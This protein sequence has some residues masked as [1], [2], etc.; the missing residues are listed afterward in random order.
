MGQ[1]GS[2]CEFLDFIA[3]SLDSLWGHL[4][5]EGGQYCSCVTGKTLHIASAAKQYD[6]SNFL[7][8]SGTVQTSLYGTCLK[9]QGVVFSHHGSIKLLQCGT[10][11]TFHVTFYRTCL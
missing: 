7:P 2:I 3:P 1:K 6:M 5:P 10:S 4:G 8:S 11:Q 9:L